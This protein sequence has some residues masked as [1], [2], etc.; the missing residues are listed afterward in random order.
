MNGVLKAAAAARRKRKAAAI[1]PE[2]SQKH[3]KYQ[4]AFLSPSTFSSSNSNLNLNQDLYS[5]G[6]IDLTGESP[7]LSPSSSNTDAIDL[8]SEQL[9]IE[10]KLEEPT[11]AAK[12]RRRATKLKLQ[13]KKQY[14]DQQQPPSTLHSQSIQTLRRVAELYSRVGLIKESNALQVSAGLLESNFDK[15]LTLTHITIRDFKRNQYGFGKQSCWIV[16]EVIHDRHKA[17]WIEQQLLQFLSTGSS[18][19]YKKSKTTE[20]QCEYYKKQG[21]FDIMKI[22]FP[23]RCNCLGRPNRM[24]KKSG[25]PFYGCRW[26]GKTG[27][28]GKDMCCHYKETVAEEWE[29]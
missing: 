5:G 27:E 23:P 9:D 2:R 18:S 14:V 24:L 6:V 12:P 3:R 19:C 7:P 29:K 17:V 15:D 10:T 11:P 13:Q 25:M 1:S 16:Q 22:E 26:Y 8:T 4:S 20:R 21:W 28:D